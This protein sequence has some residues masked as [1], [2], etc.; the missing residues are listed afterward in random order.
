MGERKTNTGIGECW[1]DG[2]ASNPPQTH[3]FMRTL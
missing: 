1:K 2:K 3:H